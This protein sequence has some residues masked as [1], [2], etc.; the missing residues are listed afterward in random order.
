MNHK[1]LIF[2]AAVAASLLSASAQAQESPFKD[3][4]PVHWAYDAVTQLAQRDI[5]RGNP[6][7][8]YGGQRGL[9]RD[10][11]AAGMQRFLR[12]AQRRIENQPY[13]CGLGLLGRPGPPGASGAPGPMGIPGVPGA[14]GVAPAEYLELERQVGPMSNDVRD[15]E[16]TW[17][18]LG[19]QLRELRGETSSFSLELQR[20]SERIEALTRTPLQDKLR[21]NFRTAPSTDDTPE[22]RRRSFHEAVREVS[23]QLAVQLRDSWLG[24]S[25]AERQTNSTP[26][27][28]FP[29]PLGHTAH[30]TLNE[31]MQM[32]VDSHPYEFKWTSHTAHTR[33]EFATVTPEFIASF[34]ARRRELDTAQRESGRSETPETSDQLAAATRKWNSRSAVALLYLVRE[35]EPEVAVNGRVSATTVRLLGAIALGAERIRPEDTQ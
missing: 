23:K 21:G 7:H 10:E 22:G 28:S 8:T 32:G 16:Q 19:A 33:G 31:L 14:P 27:A 12:E 9:T 18:Q 34:L 15:L 26:N 4:P 11:T 25:F 1:S 20:M 5:L 13:R 29:V 30:D 2:L 35:F 17:A 24:R 6:D 3:V